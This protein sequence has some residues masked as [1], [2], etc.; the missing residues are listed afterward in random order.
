MFVLGTDP[1]SVVACLRGS[2]PCFVSFAAVLIYRIGGWC[3]AVLDVKVDV[4]ARVSPGVEK[5][6]MLF[7]RVHQDDAH[8]THFG[9]I[10]WRHFVE[11]VLLQTTLLC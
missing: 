10:K 9:R 8:S 11:K 7:S 6:A 5:A 3:T 2:L 4:R 1:S